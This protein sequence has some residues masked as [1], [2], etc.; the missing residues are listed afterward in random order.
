ML[1]LSSYTFSSSSSL[2]LRPGLGLLLRVRLLGLLGLIGLARERM[3]PLLLLLPLLALLLLLTLLRLLLLEEELTLLP[4]LRFFNKSSKLSCL[5]GS[6]ARLKSSACSLY[7]SPL[8]IS[9]SR[10]KMSCSLI[11]QPAL[12]RAFISLTRLSSND[13]G[14][15]ESKLKEKNDDNDV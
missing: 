8:A 6:E 11:G 9:F 1:A 3:L 10:S 4:R 15:T 14:S 2:L 5:L 13:T 7:F 12:S